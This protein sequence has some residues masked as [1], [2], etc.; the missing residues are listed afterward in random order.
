MTNTHKQLNIPY[1]NDPNDNHTKIRKIGNIPS[2]DPDYKWWINNH[3]YIAQQA[4]LN[5]H[6]H[7]YQEPDIQFLT[8][9]P[10]KYN[11]MAG[12]FSRQIH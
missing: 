1:T 8:L 9:N 12:F 5:N 2:S 4:H 3:A 6:S 11:F 7:L 10:A